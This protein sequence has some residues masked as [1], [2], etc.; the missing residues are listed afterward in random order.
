MVLPL[1]EPGSVRLHRPAAASP[2]LDAGRDSGQDRCGIRGSEAMRGSLCLLALIWATSAPAQLRDAPPA[3]AGPSFRCTGTLSQ[4]E[5]AI[6]GDEE[7]GA[8]DRAMAFAFARKWTPW[9]GRLYSQKEWLKERNGC[10]ARKDCILRSYRQWVAGLGF[11]PRKAPTLERVVGPPP[12]GAELL[13]G[14]LQSPTG[15][16]TPLEHS[17]NLYITPIGGGWHLFSL[18]AAYYY[19]PHDGRGP[20][21]STSDVAG[22]VRLDGAAGTFRRKVED[23][24]PCTLRF[25]RLTARRWKVEEVDGP[26]GGLGTNLTGIYGR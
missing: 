13:L 3:P 10:E 23:D 5:A 19:D 25:T 15:K 1:N 24:D 14:T 17:G 21:A 20:N 2:G 7:L 4:T 8:Y 18:D 22:L 12:D 6:C 26:C 16:V 9:E 11:A